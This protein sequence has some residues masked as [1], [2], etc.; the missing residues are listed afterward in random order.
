MGQKRVHFR[1]TKRGKIVVTLVSTTLILAGTVVLREYPGI[2]F[3]LGINSPNAV[4]NASVEE[5][6]QGTI[7][8]VNFQDSYLASIVRPYN[9]VK[10]PITG[11]NTAVNDNKS[12]SP[13]IDEEFFNDAL[14]IG[15]SITE[16]ISAYGILDGA[17]I[18]AVKGLTI[19][20]AE[21]EIETIVKKHPA[22]IYILLGSNDLLYGMDSEKFSSDYMEFIQHIK[23]KLP[24]TK[25]Y[26]QS[27]FPVSKNVEGKK[28]LLSN[29]RIDE[30][31]RDLRKKAEQQGVSFID[32]S[33]LLK[34]ES[35]IMNKDFTSDGI[36]VKYKFY[37]IWLDWVKKNS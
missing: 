33:Y 1:L 16:G 13:E 11:M 21:K 12:T 23:D 34:D 10:I 26:I 6:E 27:I 30:F 3:T 22:K 14:F 37:S 25:I 5:D 15:D 4:V 31:N 24:D 17:N 2:K 18:L 9:P 35:G 29:S 20:K 32:I 28:P 19:S 8:R 36:H 7:D